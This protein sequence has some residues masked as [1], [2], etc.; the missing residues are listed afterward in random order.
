MSQ[1][2][3]L[4]AVISDWQPQFGLPSLQISCFPFYFSFHFQLVRTS[5]R[6]NKISAPLAGVF[7]AVLVVCWL[8]WGLL[9]SWSVEEK[10]ARRK[11]GHLLRSV[12]PLGVKLHWTGERKWLTCRDVNEKQ[13]LLFQFSRLCYWS[14][15]RILRPNQ[16]NAPLGNVLKT[17][18]FTRVS[19][20]LLRLSGL[21]C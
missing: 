16:P 8:L 5:A 6:R 13:L 17:C 21:L 14:T 15:R 11:H 18:Q 9:K 20:Q 3:R 19:A 1:R 4:H 7:Y 12:L 2:P 10:A